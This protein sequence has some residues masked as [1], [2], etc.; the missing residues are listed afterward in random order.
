MQATGLPETDM[1]RK[2]STLLLT[3][4]VGALLIWMAVPLAMTVYFSLVDYG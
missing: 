3:P 1:N 4:A 2:L